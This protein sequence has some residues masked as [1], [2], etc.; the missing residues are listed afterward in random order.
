MT[1]L[2]LKNKK[3]IV[4]FV[5]SLFVFFIHFR[6][7][8]VFSSSR[9]L[10]RIFSFLLPITHVAVPLFFMISAIFFYRDYCF[11]VTLQKWK[12]RFFSLCIPYLIWNTFWLVLGL[13]G[14]YTALGVLTNGVKVSFS[15]KNV[16]YGI[17]LYGKFE[18]FWFMCQLI[19]LT[20]MCPAIFLILKNKWFGIFAIA[21]YYC[22]YCFGF[23][24][25]ELLFK[26]SSMVIF[27]LI[28]AW[29]GIHYYDLFT[30]RVS[31]KHATYCLG[32][33]LVCC[34]SIGFILQ[35]PSWSLATPTTPIIKII[36]C[37]C[38][39]QLFDLFSF[40]SCASFFEESFAI[41][42]LHSF[43]GAVMAKILSILL[44]NHEF[45]VILVAVVSFPVTVIF[46]CLFALF[47][48]GYFPCFKKLLF[49]R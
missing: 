32:I 27:Y 49:G 23:R 36:S 4:S 46:I 6:T 30:H 15:L 18:P 45:F 8:S 19:L 34:I 25:P 28:G 17:F 20:A 41:Y 43:V 9:I 12:R 40:K 38:F 16:L 7:F 48:K 37:M 13:L 26:D 11:E 24:L 1:D 5:L 2:H 3:K 35:Y 22:L 47:L 29:I 10:E 42:S 44:P 39:W 31:R 21:C 33:F 14:Y